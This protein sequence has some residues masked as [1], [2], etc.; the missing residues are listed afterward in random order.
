MSRSLGS[1]RPVS[2]LRLLGSMVL[3]VGVLQTSFLPSL[4]HLEADTLSNTELSVRQE[5]GLQ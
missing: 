1:V 4:L 3:P 5:R 2:T